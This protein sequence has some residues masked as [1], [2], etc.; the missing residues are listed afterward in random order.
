MTSRPSTR[1]PTA[2]RC[3]CEGSK[4]SES[5]PLSD[6]AAGGSALLCHVSNGG[7]APGRLADL[8]FVPGTRV[9]LI[10]RAPLGDPLELCLRGTHFCLRAR[11][12]ESVW[13]HPS[14]DAP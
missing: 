2:P 13:V 7:T 10:R 14:P 1:P 9:D 8:G 5:V 3:P 6:L 11:E 12:A 4:G